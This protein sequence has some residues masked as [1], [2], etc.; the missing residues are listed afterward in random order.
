[1]N[2]FEFRR[3]ILADPRQ[4]TGEQEDHLAQ[5]AACS[6]LAREMDGL[7]ARVHDAVLVPVPEALA[8]R[9]LLRHKV[10]RPAGFGV[11]ALAA[12]LVLALAV[13]VQFYRGPAGGGDRIVTAAALGENHQAVA[14]I[15]YVLDHEPQLLQ[16]NRAGDPAVMLGAFRQL[17]LKLPA[18]DVTVRY[19]GKCPVPEGTGEHVVLRTAFGQVTLILV[20]NQPFATRVVVAYRNK[21]AV[22]SPARTGGYIV[23]ADTLKE[24]T[25]LEKLMM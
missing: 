2:C 21:A 7:E 3:L 22:A 23:V 5:C 25:R 18:K 12:S 17:G 16:E 6:Q 8:E 10:R 11:W 13:V 20:P 15:A 24:I 14:A 4:R 1:M 9:V 19:L